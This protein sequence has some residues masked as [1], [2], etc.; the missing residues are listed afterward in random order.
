MTD[1]ITHQLTYQNNKHTYTEHFR[2][3]RKNQAKIENSNATFTGYEVKFMKWMNDIED[4]V[5]NSLGL[6][7][8]DISDQNYM[9]MFEEGYTSK[10]VAD[11]IIKEEFYNYF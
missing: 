8:L 11:Y 5:F 9:V 7:L 1:K 4:L 2:N 10:D 3:T 6:Y